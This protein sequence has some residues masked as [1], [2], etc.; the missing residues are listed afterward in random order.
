MQH[1]KPMGVP[2]DPAKKPLISPVRNP[3]K[4]QIENMYGDDNRNTKTM[5]RQHM[6]HMTHMQQMSQVPHTQ[7]MQ[8]IQQQNNLNDSAVCTNHPNK[9]A[10][11]NIDIEDECMAYCGRC[12]AQLASQGFEVTKI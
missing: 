8:N 12:A 11:F 2:N 4:T 6:G 7:H 1:N 9:L 5:G 10:E 3:F